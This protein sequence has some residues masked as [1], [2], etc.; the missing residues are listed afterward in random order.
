MDVWR[1]GRVTCA[2]KVQPP[3]VYV[4]LASA[5]EACARGARALDV[6]SVHLDPYQGSETSWKDVHTNN[7]RYISTDPGPPHHPAAAA[8]PL[9]LTGTQAAHRARCRS[10]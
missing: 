7:R 9:F 6:Y 1:T 3:R 2:E 10:S 8:P 5:A 4:L